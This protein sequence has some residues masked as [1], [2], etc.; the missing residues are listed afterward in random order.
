M[1]RK[2]IPCC[3]LLIF[4]LT[5]CTR[6]TSPQGAPEAKNGLSLKMNFV[7]IGGGSFIMGHSTLEPEHKVTLSGFSIQTT[8][9]TN[10]QFEQCQNFKGRTRSKWSDKDNEPAGAVTYQEA[11]TFC[12]WLSKRDGEN[13]DLPTEAQWEFAARGGLASKDYPWGNEPSEDRGWCGQPHAKPVAQY[14]PNASGLYDMYGNIS[15]MVK[16]GYVKYTAAPRSDPFTPV[17]KHEFV[18]RGLGGEYSTPW[19][20]FR[21]IYFDDEISPPHLG[22]RV[23]RAAKP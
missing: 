1:L 7:A 22:F 20:W 4:F 2:M 15:E 16:D 13:Y 18:V 11:I 3:G 8:E 10:L 6:H 5:V 19:V 21:M 9:V 23:C 17:T 12:K 14:A